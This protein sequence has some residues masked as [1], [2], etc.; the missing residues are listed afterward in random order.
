MTPISNID[1]IMLVLRQRLSEKAG[2]ARRPAGAG[3][4]THTTG[5]RQAIA[6]LAAT[7]GVDERL[8]RRTI[9]Q[10]L[11]AEQLGESLLNDARFQEIVSQVS[12]ALEDDDKGRTLI[13]S[14]LSGLRNRR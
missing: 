7:D 8:L 5:S 9:V 3:A 6:A 13:D 1:R 4:G 14:L 12:H 10:A 11:L 2:A